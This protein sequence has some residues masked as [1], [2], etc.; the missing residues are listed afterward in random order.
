[1]R[2][3]QLVWKKTPHGGFALNCPQCG[4]LWRT[5]DASELN[6]CSCIRFIWR[7][8]ALGAPALDYSGR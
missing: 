7:D 1:M 2:I 6:P 5:D 4:A 8:G 3:D